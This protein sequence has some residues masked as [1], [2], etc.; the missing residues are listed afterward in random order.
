MSLDIFAI[1]KNCSF[2]PSAIKVL[3]DA[4]IEWIDVVASEDDTA[5]LAMV[6]ADLCI[7]AQMESV[8]DSGRT[9]IDH[10][11]HLPD[12]PGVS[13]VLYS[14]DAPGNQLAQTMVEYLSRAF[15]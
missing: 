8:N 14:L 5:A 15:N 6:S 1:S 10:G 3:E 2:R 12:L 4:D 9:A 13:I 7:S 11:G